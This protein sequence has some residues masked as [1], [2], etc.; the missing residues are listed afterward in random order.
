LLSKLGQGAGLPPFINRK[1]HVVCKQR[2]LVIVDITKKCKALQK[3]NYS[4]QK[5]FNPWIK[6]LYRI[7]YSKNNKNQEIFFKGKLGI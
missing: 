3:E 2:I 6:I 1:A 7:Y 5:Y 4:W